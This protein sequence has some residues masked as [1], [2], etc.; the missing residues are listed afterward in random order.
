MGPA[1]ITFNQR[2]LSLATAIFI[3][4][5]QF[6]AAPSA[7]C[8]TWYMVVV[9]VRQPCAARRGTYLGWLS[10]LPVPPFGLSAREKGTQAAEIT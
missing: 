6:S 8:Y 2:L 9:V 7:N 10:N 3:M 5:I 1:L 4:P